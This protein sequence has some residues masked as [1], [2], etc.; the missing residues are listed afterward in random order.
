[1]IIIFYNHHLFH[2]LHHYHHFFID[3]WTSYSI[4]SAI[5]LL[6]LAYG[7]SRI[8]SR[9]KASL[10]I[11]IDE[12]YLNTPSLQV[13][14]RQ[15][16]LFLLQALITICI[17][18]STALFAWIINLSEQVIPVTVIGT[19]ALSEYYHS[20][21]SASTL[22]YILMLLMSTCAS[23]VT[24]INFTQQTLFYLIYQFN[25][26]VMIT[27]NQFSFIFS[28]IIALS[29]LLPAII[30]LPS[31]YKS[32]GSSSSSNSNNRIDLLASN[33]SS[34]SSS[35]SSS[36][37]GNKQGMNSCRYFGNVLFEIMFSLSVMVFVVLELIVR[38]QVI[39]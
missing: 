31:H 9:S 22:S 6:F 11:E 27:M 29:I 25:W 13:R 1:M 5:A 38:E 14:Q 20:S 2:H 15:T 35:S 30:T 17:G 7:I 19:I 37:N 26:H 12:F 36:S 3:E 28:I 18:C 32:S 16:C 4:L 39:F 8:T 33:I 21:A 24:T 10:E 23:W 34:S